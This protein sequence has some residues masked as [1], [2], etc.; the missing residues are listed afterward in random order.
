MPDPK[1]VDIKVF[2]Q[3]DV[4]KDYQRLCFEEDTKM[5]T[6]L[7][8]YIEMR[9]RGLIKAVNPEQSEINS[10]K[11]TKSNHEVQVTL[12]NWMSASKRPTNAEI[13]KA[14]ANI[15]VDTKVLIDLCDRLFPTRDECT[16]AH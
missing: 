1:P 5:S 8:N 14:A 15:G 10:Q 13:I 16:N 12:V 6:D 3:P 7:R 4:K 9:C 11:P 2:V